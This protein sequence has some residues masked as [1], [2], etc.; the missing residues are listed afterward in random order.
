MKNYTLTPSFF[1]NEEYFNKYLGCTSYY[2]GLQQIASKLIEYTKSE[3]ILEMGCALCNT[4]Y[5]LA[6]RYPNKYFT[7]IDIRDVILEEA[8][9]SMDFRRHITLEQAEMCSYAKKDLSSFDMIYMLYSFHHIPDPLKNKQQFIEDCYKNMKKDA[10]L[11]IMETFLPEEA[12]TMSFDPTIVELFHYRSE[13]GYASTF[14]EALE[15][16]EEDKIVKAREV[17]KVS[18]NEESKA[19]ENVYDRQDEFLVKFSWLEDLALK[20]GFK[21]VLAEPVNAIQEKAILLQK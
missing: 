9:K 17:A 14:W 13:E 6:D 10:Y 12:E 3:N 5:F 1:T 21:V 15:S 19:G 20:T 8:S 16:L 7:G 2:K 4:L 11:L 18:M